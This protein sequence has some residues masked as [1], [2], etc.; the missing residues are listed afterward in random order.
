MLLQIA[1]H[2]LLHGK[3]HKIL[4]VSGTGSL[5]ITFLNVG[6]KCLRTSRQAPKTA[7]SAPPCPL[8][9]TLPLVMPRALLVRQ[10]C[11]G[12]ATALLL[13]SIALV[14]KPTGFA[15]RPSS[16]PGTRV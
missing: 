16:L 4:V 7:P 9:R 14:S 2:C 13:L 1:R 11:L 6:H 15:L 8:A 12:L 3:P 5:K 10:P